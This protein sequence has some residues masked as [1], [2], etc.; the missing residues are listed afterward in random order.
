M[1]G[2]L[3]W[4]PR[5]RVRKRNRFDY[6]LVSCRTNPIAA[7]FSDDVTGACSPRSQIIES[8]IVTTTMPQGII[9]EIQ[10]SVGA[11]RRSA[12]HVSVAPAPQANAIIFDRERHGVPN[13][14]S[15][16]MK[17]ANGKPTT[18]SMK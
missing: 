13:A 10:K 3:E 15:D 17:T 18:R 2:I 16:S 14:Q 9:G 4:I 6:A 8:A 12:N 11:K 5:L 7:T 1:F